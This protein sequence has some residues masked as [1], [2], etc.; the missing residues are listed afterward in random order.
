MRVKNIVSTLLIPAVML[1]S[2][3]LS[4]A[5]TDGGSGTETDPYLIGSVADWNEFR[6]Y[7][8]DDP[9]GA[10]ANTGSLPR[11]LTLLT[12]KEIKAGLRE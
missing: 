3:S 1:C 2:V 12:Q 6:R 5:Y 10:R 4:F 8:M 9:D 11:I 7:V